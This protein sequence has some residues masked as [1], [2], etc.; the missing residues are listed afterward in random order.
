[1]QTVEYERFVRPHRR[2]V[3]QLLLDFEFFQ[4]DVGPL[5]V[6][7]VESRIKT[8]ESAMAKA[9]RLKIPLDEIQDIAGIRIVVGTRPEVAI[10]KRFFQR[11]ADIG[12]DLVIAKDETIARPSGYRST[13][14][15]TRFAGNYSR[16]AQPGNLE[17]QIPTT[18]EHSFNFIS[19]AWV[20]KSSTEHAPQWKSDFLALSKKLAALD[21]DA[22]QLHRAAV[23]TGR[24]DPEKEPLTPL[25]FQRLAKDQFG[26]A[27]RIED[28]VDYC[29]WYLDLGISRLSE[30]KDFFASA[31][32]ETLWDEFASFEAETGSDLIGDKSK[33]LF[34]GAFGT[35][36]E[37]AREYLA[38]MRSGE[39]KPAG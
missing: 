16:S 31:E 37:Y 14:L 17:I 20:Y 8:R 24:F 34:W 15:I 29:H 38:K 2:F 30:L 18:F 22:G 9:D 26:E 35:R 5:G 4:E 13:H 3:R 25:L 21:E 7:S 1:M 39:W 11:R 10:V 23:D 19:R 28:A 12:D 6:F 33:I 36:R 27:V 32:V